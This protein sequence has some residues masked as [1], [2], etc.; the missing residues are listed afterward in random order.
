MADLLPCF[1]PYP[2]L[3]WQHPALADQVGRLASAEGKCSALGCLPDC[4]AFPMFSVL[5]GAGNNL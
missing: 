5:L 2:A 1:T 3:H 4:A